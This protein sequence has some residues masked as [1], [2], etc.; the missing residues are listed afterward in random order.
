MLT[1]L[2]AQGILKSRPATVKNVPYAEY[3]HYFVIEP[4]AWD[5]PKTGEK[6]PTRTTRVKR[7][8][9]PWLHE[10][11]TTYLGYRPRPGG[12]ARTR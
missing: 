2:R 3:L 9:I 6:I 1:E 5:H 12:P 4:Q 11:L 8:S 7:S 10:R